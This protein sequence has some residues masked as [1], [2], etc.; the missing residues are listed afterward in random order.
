MF[1]AGNEL[2]TLLCIG[3]SI[4]VFS[5]GRQF[6]KCV[7]FMSEKNNVDYQQTHTLTTLTL[8]L[9]RQIEED[10]YLWENLA[11]KLLHVDVGCGNG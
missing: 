6:R 10:V 7:Y 9:Q 5:G 1:S 4:N 11:T 2:Y 3:F 8:T